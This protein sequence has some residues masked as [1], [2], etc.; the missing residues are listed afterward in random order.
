LRNV[1]GLEL[2]LAVAALESEGMAVKTVEVSSRKGV[3]GNERR[4]VRAR[5]TGE[6]SAELTYAVFKTSVDAPED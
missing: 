1:E 2:S 3:N 4:V 5:Q 6:N